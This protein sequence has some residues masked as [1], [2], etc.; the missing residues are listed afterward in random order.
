MEEKNDNI[1][2]KT[3]T[4]EIRIGHVAGYVRHQRERGTMRGRFFIK[5]PV[6][7]LSAPIPR[8]CSIV[9][10][11][12]IKPNEKSEVTY[13]FMVINDDDDDAPNNPVR[14]RRQRCETRSCIISKISLHRGFK[15]TRIFSPPHPPE[16][17]DCCNTC[18]A[19][20]FARWYTNSVRSVPNPHPPSVSRKSFCGAYYH[21]Y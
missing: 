20:V 14:R 11:E 12:K 4:S 15:S 17:A 10:K 21:Y 19:D 7:I 16:S 5:N 3:W 13:N 2:G 18:A 6:Q 1:A 9:R 8:R